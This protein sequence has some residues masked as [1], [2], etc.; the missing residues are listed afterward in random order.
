MKKILF[1]LLCAAC[2]AAVSCSHPAQPQPEGSTAVTDEQPGEET[3][4]VTEEIRIRSFS[5][6]NKDTK[7]DDHAQESVSRA[8]V[9]L[10]ARTYTELYKLDTSVNSPHYPRVS[11]M[12]DGRYIMTYMEHQYGSSIYYCT[13]DDITSWSAPLPLFR[14]FAIDG[15]TDKR[16]YMNCDTLVLEN[17]DILAFSSFRADKGY[18]TE[19]DKNGIAMI[20]SRDNGKTW[21]E[22]QVIYTGTNWETD[23]ILLASGEIQLYFTET[24][25]MIYKYGF[26]DT[27]RSSGIGLIRS[28]DNGET[29]TP[30]VTGAPY[31]AQ[32]VMQQF[33]GVV[34]GVRHYT[35]QMP[36]AVALHSGNIALAVESYLIDGKYRISVGHTTDNW[37]KWLGEDEPGPD[38]RENN[39]FA[40]VGPS[41][42]QFESGE[43]LLSHMASSSNQL[44]IGDSNAQNFGR[45]YA[46]YP[47]KG[48]WGG[49][50]ID[51]THSAVVVYPNVETNATTTGNEK[52]LVG[53]VYLNHTLFTKK[54]TP[55]I[56]GSNSDWKDNTEA[57]FVG[58]ESQAQA[59]VSVCYDDDNIYFLAERLDSYLETGDR[60]T[61]YFDAEGSS[62]MY[63]LTLGLNGIEKLTY[64]KSFNPAEVS[65]DGIECAVYT[66]GIPDSAG[67]GKD[68]GIMYELSV[69]RSYFAINDNS[70]AFMFSLDN[71][72]KGEKYAT[73]TFS[74]STEFAKSTWPLIKLG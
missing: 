17:G 31:A 62:A 73:D 71:T 65:P 38:E 68:T 41:L 63:A 74:L 20:R 64:S 36:A 13:A 11:V 55:L 47:V 5:E 22:E 66:D 29:W 52:L 7:T 3:G 14:S 15:G 19:L 53:R 45:A 4:A 46:V 1:L 72:D 37:S 69:P 2:A 44:R 33:A 12:A 24:A 16:K 48:L 54:M 34:D 30:Y 39:L 35:D 25:P 9:E 6:L 40:G 28:C 42:V 58:S 70:F 21:S 57:L 43:T 61:L 60:I 50:C 23:A 67:G 56:D 10:D 26:N 8:S 27:R 32:Q 18:K 51:E 59:S 49:L